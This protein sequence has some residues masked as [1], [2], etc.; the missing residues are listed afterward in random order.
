MQLEELKNS[1]N[2]ASS[3]ETAEGEEQAPTPKEEV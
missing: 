1:H 2:M 3:K